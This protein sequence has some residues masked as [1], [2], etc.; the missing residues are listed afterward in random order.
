MVSP[1][2]R[3]RKPGLAAS[4]A[5]DV[6]M[7]DGESEEEVEYEDEPDEHEMSALDYLHSQGLS[8]KSL[9]DPSKAK[10]GATCRAEGSSRDKD[11][12]QKE[13]AANVKAAM[14]AR[15]KK[16]LAEE[17]EK[18]AKKEGGIKWMPLLFLLVSV[19]T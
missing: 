1:D 19:L 5:D 17:N 4:E 12:G 10:T 15:R 14:K 9:K 8:L 7:D 18:Q 6:V 16:A 13:V 2:I 3:Q 11:G